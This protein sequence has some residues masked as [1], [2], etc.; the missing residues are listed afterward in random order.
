MGI[1]AGLEMFG[2]VLIIPFL[3]LVTSITPPQELSTISKLVL[4]TTD[5]LQIELTL[6]LVLGLFL[7]LI[8]LRA[9]GVWQ[10]DMHINKIS[11]DFVQH[12]LS[13]VGTAIVMARWQSLVNS[14]QSEM[15]LIMNERLTIKNCTVTLLNT[16]VRMMLISG[17]L[18]LVILISPLA[19]LFILPISALPFLL[20]KW[21]LKLPNTLSRRHVSISKKQ[22]RVIRHFISS[23]KLV[24]SSSLEEQHIRQYVNT[25]NDLQRNE[26]ETVSAQSITRMLTEIS[27]AFILVVSAWWC[28]STAML[29]LPE[30]IVITIVFLRLVPDLLII[31][32]EIQ[33]LIHSL[34]KFLHLKQIQQRLQKDKD[35]LV[36]SNG[37]PFT[38]QDTLTIQNATFTYKTVAENRPALRNIEL[39]IPAKNITA[40]TGISGSGKTTLVDI[41]LGLLEPDNGEIFVDGIPMLGTNRGGW[42]HSIAYVPQE[43]YLFPDTIRANL[44]WMQ[45]GATD[46]EI[47]EALQLASADKFVA[48]LPQGLD[49]FVGDLGTQISGGERQRLT[50][51]RALIR[52]PALLILDESTSQ[53]DVETEQQILVTLSALCAHTT[54]VIVSHH[55]NVL[56]QADQIIWLDSGQVLAT[57]TWH[58]LAANF[59]WFEYMITDIGDNT[60]SAMS[61]NID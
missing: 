55:L 10:R 49:S 36:E 39:V 46:A 48:N 41:L 35:R 31:Q 11:L 58:E 22:T 28:L 9:L 4:S 8:T 26:I 51:A 16:M 1:T 37:T 3:Y 18:L 32:K 21:L 52:K 59:K 7:G 45:P 40:I 25:I 47:W 54:I 12:C 14:Q 50:L 60:E 43:V 34:P 13:K 20:K 61:A 19:L 6:T 23:L 2:L 5:T 56:Q 42:R 33:Y 15:Q 24:K 30:L 27:F 17:K 29:A 53:L 44:L 38:F 57:G